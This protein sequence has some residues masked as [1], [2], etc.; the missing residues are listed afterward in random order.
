MITPLLSDWMRHLG[1]WCLVVA[2]LVFVAAIVV[3]ATGFEP[4]F[5]AMLFALGL[6]TFGVG[7]VSVGRR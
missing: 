3:F 4:A 7:A 2:V 1:M 6:F 5:L